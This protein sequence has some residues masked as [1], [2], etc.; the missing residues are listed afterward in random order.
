MHLLYGFPSPQALFPQISEKYFHKYRFFYIFASNHQYSYATFT[1]PQDSCKAKPKAD[2]T[3]FLTNYL[4][5][6]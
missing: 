2:N 3:A 4:L 5:N 1:K 6:G